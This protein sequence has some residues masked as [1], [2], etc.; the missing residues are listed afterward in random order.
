MIEDKFRAIIPEINSRIFFTLNSL[1]EDKPSTREI[2]WPW[3][4]VGNRP[5]RNTGLKDNEENEIYGGDVVELNG[6]FGEK[7][8]GVIELVD[9]CW[10]ATYDKPRYNVIDRCNRAGLYLKCFVVNHAVKVS[11]NIHEIPGFKRKL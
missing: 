1:L 7:W 5:D 6:P 3:L 8:K 10:V 9:G 4:K 11:G 2:L